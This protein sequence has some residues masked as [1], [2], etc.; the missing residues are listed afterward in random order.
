MGLGNWLRRTFGKDSKVVSLSGQPVYHHGEAQQ[1]PFGI[2]DVPDHWAEEREKHYERWLGP[3][4]SHL[5]LDGEPVNLLW[6]NPITDAE[7]QLKLKRGMDAL[8]ELMKRR[9]LPRV[10]DVHRRSLI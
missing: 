2:A 4:Q 10:L 9:D 6:L 8:V 1:R 3:C 7:C 5:Q